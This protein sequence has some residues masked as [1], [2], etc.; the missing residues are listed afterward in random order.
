MNYM[1][2]Q[3]LALYEKAYNDATR[4]SQANNLPL[5][6]RKFTEA[7]A[8]SR[9][10][11]SLDPTNKDSYLKRAD[12]LANIA[13]GIQAKMDQCSPVRTSASPVRGGSTPAGGS[14]TQSAETFEIDENMSAF[15]TFYRTDD[16]VGGFDQVIGLEEAKEAVTEY[17]INPIRYPEAYNYTF[18]DNKC[19]LLEGPPGTGKTTFAKAVAKEINQP[20]ALVNV[21]GLVNCYVGETAKTIDKVFASL[22]EFASRNNCGITVFFDEFD[23]IA[24]SREGDDKASQTSVPA[25]L[26]NLDGVQQNKNFLIIANTNCVD[27]LDRG[28]RDRFRRKIHIPLPDLTMRKRFFKDKLAQLEP[29]YFSKL[30]LD[31]LAKASEGLSGRAISQ[32]CDDFL[33][34]VGGVKAGLKTCENFNDVLINMIHRN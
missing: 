14:F 23:E 31:E 12:K 17:V 3:Y 29:E 8:Y 10:L 15:Y 20:F 4:A 16:L 1:T 19:I 7:A 28:I 18:M 24:K 34:F 22:R 25:L 30:N 9:K 6:H 32:I 11:A 21:A 26:R 27:M 33:H 2:D 5:A 13:S